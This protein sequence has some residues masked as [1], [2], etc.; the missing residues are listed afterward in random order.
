VDADQDLVIGRNS[1]PLDLLDPQIPDAVQARRAH[2]GLAAGHLLL[3]SKDERLHPVNKYTHG[4][5]TRQ[6][7][8]FCIRCCVLGFT[9]TN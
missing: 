9:T 4:F 1:R 7:V 2:A 6:L 3:P 5:C 8:S